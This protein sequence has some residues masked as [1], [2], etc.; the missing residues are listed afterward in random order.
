MTDMNVNEVELN[1]V[2]Y[3][4]KDSVKSIDQPEGDYVVV[5]TYSAGVHAG[6]LKERNGKEV[7]L[8]NTRRLWYWKGASTL[9]Q[10]AGEG[11]TSPEECKFPA[12][13]AEITLT[14]AIEVIPCTTKAREIIQGVKE[15]MS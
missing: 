5:R 7:T 1:G 8:T 11:I 2:K 10:V 14:E 12:A 4:R 6:Y 15:W 9:S 3:V 13:I